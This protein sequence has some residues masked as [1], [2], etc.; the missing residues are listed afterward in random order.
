VSVFLLV[1]GLFILAVTSSD[2]LVTT[3]TL[4]GGGFLSNRLSSW[5]WH[6]ATKMHRYH[7]PTT[8]Y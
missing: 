6:G 8:V 7:I 5:L 2:A 1:I 3:L 4:R